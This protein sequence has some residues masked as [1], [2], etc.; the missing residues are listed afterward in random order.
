MA[1][2]DENKKVVCLILFRH[3]TKNYDSDYNLFDLAW[4]SI[5]HGPMVWLIDGM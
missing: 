2:W 3:T 1:T 5:P 4:T